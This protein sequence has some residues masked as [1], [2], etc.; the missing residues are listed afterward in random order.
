MS[1]AVFHALFMLFVRISQLKSM[2]VFG[3]CLLE[4]SL[5]SSR[6][7]F[8]SIY[9]WQTFAGYF[10]IVNGIWSWWTCY[11]RYVVNILFDKIVYY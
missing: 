11:Y 6:Y 5:V 9:I 2:I 7:V 8:S 1:R 4:C 10:V 3:F